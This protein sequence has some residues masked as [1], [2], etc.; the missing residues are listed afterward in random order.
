MSMTFW[1]SLQDIPWPD[2]PM[3]PK[4]KAENR[5]IT[6][7]RKMGRQEGYQAAVD[8]TGGRLKAFPSRGSMA[9]AGV[10]G[11]TGQQGGIDLSCTEPLLL[12]FAWKENRFGT[13]SSA[14]SLSSPHLC[15]ACR[16]LAPSVITEGMRPWETHLWELK[17]G[18]SS[19]NKKLYTQQT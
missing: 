6:K 11:S 15:P 14:F 4:R 17:E 3:D 9:L 2:E 16:S 19:Q 5:A 13:G 10:A 8:G 1:K 7:G 12:C 18:Q